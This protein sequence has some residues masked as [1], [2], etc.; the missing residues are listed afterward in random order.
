VFRPGP[1][2][3]AA[4]SPVD[5]ACGF[6]GACAISDKSAHGRTPTAATT[7][8]SNYRG[9]EEGRSVTISMQTLSDVLVAIVT[10]VGIAV[11]VSIAFV[12]AGALFERGQARTAKA[13]RRP[14]AVLAQHPTQSDDAGELL[15][16]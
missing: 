1:A 8:V 10:T 9:R 15:L 7:D 11:A 2:G 13:R 12:A 4:A 5:L 14:G 3:N 16:R 6:E